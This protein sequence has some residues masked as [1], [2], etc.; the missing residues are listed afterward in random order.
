MLHLQQHL[1]EIDD[2]VVQL[3]AQIDV[4]RVKKRNLAQ[5]L[6][7]AQDE[8][9]AMWTKVRETQR[10]RKIEKKTLQERV[11]DVRQDTLKTE[12][13]TARMEIEKN[14]LEAKIKELELAG[15]GSSK[16]NFGFKKSNGTSWRQFAAQTAE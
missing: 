8:L 15:S 11:E 10:Q 14:E 16:N 12:R 2:M 7:Q 4:R 5:D 1:K 13:E 6:K 3:R 9:T